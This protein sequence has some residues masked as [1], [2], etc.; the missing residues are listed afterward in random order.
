[1]NPDSL[2]G[3]SIDWKKIAFKL[4][5][6]DSHSSPSKL[7]EVLK[8]E[9]SPKDASLV[10]KREWYSYTNFF[11]DEQAKLYSKLTGFSI[12]ESRAR[13][14]KEVLKLSSDF[15]EANTEIPPQ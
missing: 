2:N 8:G 1:M 13:V 6:L 11:M 3:I 10:V 12:A 15:I 14:T 7:A 4:A 5:D 9:L